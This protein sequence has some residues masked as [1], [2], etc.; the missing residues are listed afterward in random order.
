[1]Y[2]NLKG[3]NESRLIA[4]YKIEAILKKAGC[5]DD[6]DSARK[7]CLVELVLKNSIGKNIAPTNY[8][9]LSP[10]KEAFLPNSSLTVRDYTT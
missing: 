3:S 6:E 8:V 10:L 9:Y 5:G 4:K 1:M 2:K 7:N